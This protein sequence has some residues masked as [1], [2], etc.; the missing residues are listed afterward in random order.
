MYQGV[1]KFG[2]GVTHGLFQ[3]PVNPD[4]E[5]DAAE[6]GARAA[7]IWGRPGYDQKAKADN[8]HECG[9][10]QQCKEKGGKRY[11]LSEFY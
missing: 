5:R 7:T 11:A 6:E 10:K 2:G 4:R 3:T 8:F 1:A 9:G